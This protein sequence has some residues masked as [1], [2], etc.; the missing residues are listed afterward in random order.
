MSMHDPYDLSFE[1]V[2]D[3]IKSLGLRKED[4]LTRN[5]Y[6][7]VEDEDVAIIKQAVAKLEASEVKRRRGDWACEA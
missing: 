1:S 2:N 3:A 5:L 6:E 4:V 7:L